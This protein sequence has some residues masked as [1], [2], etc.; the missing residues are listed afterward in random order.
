VAL[1]TIYA[2]FCSTVTRAEQDDFLNALF[3]KTGLP[4][5]RFPAAAHYD[6][7]VIRGKVG[8]ALDGFQVDA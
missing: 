8:K 6:P 4:L 1:F 2:R 3:E 7:E 5:H